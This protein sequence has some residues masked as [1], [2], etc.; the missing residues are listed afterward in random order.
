MVASGAIFSGVKLW[1]AH[2]G[3]DR[4]RG[5]FFGGAGDKSHLKCQQVEL[6]ARTRHPLSR[7]SVVIRPG[8]MPLFI[9]QWE[10]R[11]RL[12]RRRGGNH[13]LRIS[14]GDGISLAF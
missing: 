8:L 4:I 2:A 5:H 12:Y 3:G 7:C 1:G 14:S 11:Y 6:L 10:N 13:L 9:S